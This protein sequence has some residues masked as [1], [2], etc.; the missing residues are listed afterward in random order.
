M[1]TIANKYP[2][3]NEFWTAYRRDFFE[4]HKDLVLRSISVFVSHSVYNYW[5]NSHYEPYEG[6]FYGKLF[7]KISTDSISISQKQRI[8]ENIFKKLNIES[9]DLFKSGSETKHSKINKESKITPQTTEY[10]NI[11]YT[12]GEDMMSDTFGRAQLLKQ[13]TKQLKS[14]ERKETTG[15]RVV[16]EDGSFSF[17]PTFDETTA[18]GDKTWLGKLLS[19]LS[20]VL[21]EFNPRTYSF[22]FDKL[23]GAQGYLIKLPSGRKKWISTPYEEEEEETAQPTRKKEQYPD[24]TWEEWKEICSEKG[25]TPIQQNYYLECITRYYKRK[26]KEKAPVGSLTALGIEK[27]KELAEGLIKAWE[28]DLNVPSLEKFEEVMNNI[29]G[30][31]EFKDKMR[32]YLLNLADDI[33]EGKKTEQTIYV[34]LGPPGIGK[35]YISEKLAEAM[36]RPLINLDLGGR[37]DTGILEGVS[38]SVKAAYAGRIVQGIATGK[39]RGAIILLD[40]FEKVR[41]EGLANMIGNVLDI[42]KNKDWFDQFLGYRVD[43]TDC[44]I[45]CTA[46]YADQVPD[47]VQDRAEMVNIELATYRQRVGY[48]MGSLKKKLR[49]SSKTSYAAEQLTEEFCKY[50]ITET[51]GYRQTNANMEQVYKVLRG[52]VKLGRRIE[53]FTEFSS[54]EESPNRFVF[55]YSGGQKLSLVRIRTENVDGQS[56]L[57]EELGLDWPDFGFGSVKVVRTK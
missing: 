49:G 20:T 25:D 2:T 33:E 11:P 24:I 9:K 19:N 48:V 27:Q 16:N 42:K 51:W 1:T 13:Q 23:V 12:Q 40:E 30:Y 54:V 53:N 37:S 3:Y 35:S 26:E 45:L 15:R 41:D 18:W 36:E 56:V 34:L 39:N 43:L 22:L 31:Q 17:Q 14:I 7:S 44:I 29:V 57:S 5:K 46:N 55:S 28:K 52:Y 10:T 38:P 32:M 8:Y 21:F 4:L 47:F 6:V 50:L